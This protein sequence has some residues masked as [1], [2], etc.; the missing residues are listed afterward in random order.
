VG[1][2]ASDWETRPL[3]RQPKTACNEGTTPEPEAVNEGTARAACNLAVTEKERRSEDGR[4]ER[5]GG[6]PGSGLRGGVARNSGL[7]RPARVK[8][9][10]GR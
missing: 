8:R 1:R 9:R 2:T 6:A 3:C 4:A 5:R 10:V 7:E